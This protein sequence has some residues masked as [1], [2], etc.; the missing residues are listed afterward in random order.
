MGGTDPGAPPPIPQTCMPY[1]NPTAAGCFV[2]FKADILEKRMGAAGT[3]G[4]AA[5]GCH[6]P[7][8]GVAPK[9]DVTDPLGTYINL[10]NSGSGAAPYINPCSTDPSKSEIIGNLSSPST[11]GDHMPKGNSALPAQSEIDKVVR[12][13]VECGAPFN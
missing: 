4:C 6:D 7:Q 1:A 5:S 13:W 10:Y 11:A 9:I 3:W 8:G 2:S 12:P